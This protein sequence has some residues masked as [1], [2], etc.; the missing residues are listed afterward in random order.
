V[1]DL[2]LS[3]PITVELKVANNLCR[4]LAKLRLK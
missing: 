3:N 2:K 1:K 4:H